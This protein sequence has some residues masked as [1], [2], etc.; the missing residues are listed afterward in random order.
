MALPAPF[1]I[2]SYS[3]H[4]KYCSFDVITTIAEIFQLPNHRKKSNAFETTSGHI[5]HHYRFI[6]ELK[7]FSAFERPRLGHPYLPAHMPGTHPI[8]PHSN[9]MKNFAKF[10]H[11]TAKT[12]PFIYVRFHTAAYRLGRYDSRFSV[13]FREGKLCLFSRRA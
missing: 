4:K 2:L 8:W 9:C 13:F 5:R 10:A 11:N 3:G 1:I 6:F 12:R 7:H